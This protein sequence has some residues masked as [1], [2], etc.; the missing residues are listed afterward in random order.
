MS[1]MN[2]SAPA[3]KEKTTKAEI[4]TPVIFII[5]SFFSKKKRE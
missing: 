2:P 4:R 3:L 1:L 5:L